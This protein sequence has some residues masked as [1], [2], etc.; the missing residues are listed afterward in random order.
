MVGGLRLWPLESLDCSLLAI[1]KAT[2]V[3]AKAAGVVA[4]ATCVVAKGTDV[5]VVSGVFKGT[6]CKRPTV[7]KS[8]FTKAWV[9]LLLVSEL[10]VM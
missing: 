8:T 5:V 2:G 6:T 4:K 1:A 9:L 7:P 3:V 10:L